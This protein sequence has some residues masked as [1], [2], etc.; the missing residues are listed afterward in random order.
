M[1]ECCR[2]VAGVERGFRLGQ[3]GVGSGALGEVRAVCEAGCGA[4]VASEFML[5]QRVW[6]VERWAK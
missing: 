5:G 1:G 3:R 6:V 2:G 4:G